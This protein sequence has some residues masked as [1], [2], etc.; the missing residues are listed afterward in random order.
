[1]EEAKVK[2]VLFS[3]RTVLGIPLVVLTDRGQDRD[4][5]RCSGVAEVL[6][7]CLQIEYADV[8]FGVP[9]EGRL[10]HVAVVLRKLGDCGHGVSRQRGRRA[11]SRTGCILLP[12]G[13]LRLVGPSTEPA[14]HGES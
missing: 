9:N 3:V 4:R 1:M 7:E 5:R 6:R 8:G 14:G 2:T 10:L 11:Y 13:R 12:R